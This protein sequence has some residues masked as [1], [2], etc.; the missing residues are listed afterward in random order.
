VRESSVRIPSRRQSA[1]TQ[2]YDGRPACITAGGVVGCPTGAKY[3]VVATHLARA[4]QRGARVIGEAFVH[5]VNY[6]AKNG[7]VTGVDYLDAQRKEHRL[8]ARLV[9][10]AAH[11]LETPRLLLLSSNSTFPNGLA[12]SSGL[13]GRNFMSHP[14][15]SVYR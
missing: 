3:I 7:G 9:V 6:D 13:V 4:E 8:N 5:R 12:N 1:S 2:E 11:A 10:L 15:W 14:T